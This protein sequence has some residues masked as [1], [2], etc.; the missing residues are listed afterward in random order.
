MAAVTC[1]PNRVGVAP[2]PSDTGLFAEP[3]YALAVRHEKSVRNSQ[4]PITTRRLAAAKRALRN[5]R[6]A[7]PLL[8]AQIA[9]EQPTP[10]ERIRS[11]DEANA[12]HWQAVRDH[13]AQV[14]RR[15][16]ATIRALPD[17]QRDALLDAWNRSS[18]PASA[19]Y[20][21]DFVRRFLEADRCSG[22]GR[23]LVDPPGQG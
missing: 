14:W 23:D 15:A 2:C 22:S 3:C 6:N 11:H 19:A 12:D 18:I 16:R 7:H 4:R 9:D 8:A 5:E 21:A 1:A 10:E 17:E 20:F 13:R